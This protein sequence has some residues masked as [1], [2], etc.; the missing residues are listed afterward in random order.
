MTTH[1][2]SIY[3]DGQCPVCTNYVRYYRLQNGGSISLI[4]LRQHPEKVRDFN[5]RGLNVDEGMI[6]ELDRQTYHGVGAV[7]MLALLSTPV[8]AFN[9]INRWVFSRP[10]LARVLYPVLVSG[11]NT[12]LRLLGRKKILAEA[13]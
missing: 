8:G 3:Y 13:P 1:H 7:H 11:R 9:R 10:R 6:L 2:L 4:D 12:L 5:A